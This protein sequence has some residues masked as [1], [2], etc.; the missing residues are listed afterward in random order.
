VNKLEGLVTTQNA[1]IEELKKLL[2]DE[3]EKVRA[4]RNDLEKYAQCF[5]QV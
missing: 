2:K 3:S 1:T 4:L 5:T